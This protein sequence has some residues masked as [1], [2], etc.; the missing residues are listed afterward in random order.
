VPDERLLIE[1]GLHVPLIPLVEVFGSAGTAAPEHMFNE[2]P[3]AN[4]GTTLGLTVITF[5]TVSPHVP[6]DGVK[7]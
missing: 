4:V 5:V 1:A 3:K 6:D 2:V 7:V